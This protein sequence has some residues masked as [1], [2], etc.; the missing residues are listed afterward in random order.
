MIYFHP[1]DEDVDV[2]SLGPGD[3]QD[4]VEGRVRVIYVIHSRELTANEK[5]QYR[6]LSRG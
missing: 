5:R 6:R 2:Q 4:F 1:A 3:L